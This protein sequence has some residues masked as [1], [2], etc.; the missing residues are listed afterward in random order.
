M[1]ETEPSAYKVLYARYAVRSLPNDGG[2]VS[3]LRVTDSLFERTRTTAE[4]DLLP[5]AL[6]RYAALGYSLS[7]MVIADTG[8]Q[9]PSYIIV[10]QHASAP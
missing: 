10:L 1:T 5:Q 9:P 4:D 6:N 2:V 8:K 7:Q 3:E